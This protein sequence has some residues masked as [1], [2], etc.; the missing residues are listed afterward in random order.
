MSYSHRKDSRTDKQFASDIKK[1]HIKE[2]IYG[3]AYRLQLEFETGQD[4]IYTPYGCD[5]TGD[6]IHGHINDIADALYSIGEEEKLVEIKT[7]PESLYKFFTFK[8]SALRKCLKHN[9]DLIV[10]KTGEFWVCSNPDYIKEMVD[11]LEHKIYYAFSPN[12]ISVR[13]T[14]DLIDYYFN[15]FEWTDSASQYISEN[16]HKLL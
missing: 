3:E 2:G 5:P 10:C 4:V 15:Y 6:V 12:D 8:V 1:A 14:K 9:A 11:F 16:R 13:L 7:C